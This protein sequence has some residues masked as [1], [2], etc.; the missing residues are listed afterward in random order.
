MEEYDIDHSQCEIMVNNMTGA[1]VLYRCV[2][3]GPPFGLYEPGQGPNPCRV[4]YYKSFDGPEQA[5]KAGWRQIGDYWQCPVCAAKWEKEYLARFMN[6]D[7][8]RR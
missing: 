5:K 1:R 7:D 4:S 6:W 3:H 8:L 2:T